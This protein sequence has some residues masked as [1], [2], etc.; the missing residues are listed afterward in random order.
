MLEYHSKFKI[1]IPISYQNFSQSNVDK[2]DLPKT[3]V[4]KLPAKRYLIGCFCCYSSEKEIDVESY[5]SVYP[6]YYCERHLSNI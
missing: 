3:F 6:K 1:K 2:V 5:A 4:L